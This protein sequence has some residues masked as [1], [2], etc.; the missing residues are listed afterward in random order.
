[1]IKEE[2]VSKDE[3]FEK[4]KND[5]YKVYQREDEKKEKK[6]VGDL[7]FDCNYCNEK[8]HFAKECI[9]SERKRD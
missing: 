1:M 3:R 6:L 8:N 9:L 4:I 5:G 2:T 7:G